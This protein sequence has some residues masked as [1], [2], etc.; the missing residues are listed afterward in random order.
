MQQ[1]IKRRT[2]GTTDFN[3]HWVDYEKGF[4]NVTEEF[5]IGKSR[6]D[7]SIRYLINYN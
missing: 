3:R 7:F 4:V 6:E 2:G 5:W 1:V